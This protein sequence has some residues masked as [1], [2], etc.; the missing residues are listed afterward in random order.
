L[1]NLSRIDG[2]FAVA[3]AINENKEVVLQP[4]DAQL[5]KGLDSKGVDLGEYKNF[6]YKGRFRPVDLLLTG[7]FR[8]EEDVITDNTEFI[9]IDTDP[10]TESLMTRYG[11]NI[12]GLPDTE[13][14]STAQ[15]LAPFVI[16]QLER[17]IS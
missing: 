10:K 14:E 9:Y 1:L 7:E 4:N 3:E 11:E 15:R 13:F 16:N 17:Q 12:I 2:N 6:K 5:D 8:D